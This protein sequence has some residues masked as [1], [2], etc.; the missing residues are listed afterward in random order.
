MVYMGRKQ[1]REANLDLFERAD[2]GED[3]IGIP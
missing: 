2:R 3:S 1:P